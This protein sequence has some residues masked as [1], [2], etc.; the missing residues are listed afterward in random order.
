MRFGSKCFL[1]W[2][3]VAGGFGWVWGVWAGMLW[4]GFAFGSVLFGVDLVFVMCAFWF[5]CCVWFV[6]LFALFAS[7]AMTMADFGLVRTYTPPV[8]NNM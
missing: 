6:I 2:G 5:W 4:T 1:F 7:I 8:M 3:W